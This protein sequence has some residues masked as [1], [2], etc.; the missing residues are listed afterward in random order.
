MT[1]WTTPENTKCAD[2]TIF[3]V[4]TKCAKKFVWARKTHFVCRSFLSVPILCSVG[5]N[6]FLSVS[7][8]S[9]TR[10]MLLLPLLML[11]RR[12]Q[13]R[14]QLGYFRQSLTATGRRR[15]DRRIKRISLTAPSMSPFT[16]LFGAG[17]DQS[18]I[19]VTGLDHRAFCSL[20]AL[21][22]QF[23]DRFTPYSTSGFI[24]QRSVSAMGR[25]RSLDSTSCLAL[26]LAWTRTRGSTMVL[27]MLFGITS[28]VCSLYLRFGRRLSFAL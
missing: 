18:L 7:C 1:Q 17:C 13:A 9:L 8:P 6:R 4:R 14:R 10:P 20:L 22:S 12:R 5:T 21:F 11:L 26:A 24:R 28:S 27:C 19:T 23:Y 2:C 3:F 15:R 16:V 25:P